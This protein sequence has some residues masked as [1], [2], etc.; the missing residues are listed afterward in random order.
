MYVRGIHCSVC[1]YRSPDNPSA[2]EAFQKAV[3][4][5]LMTFP[6]GYKVEPPFPLNL[7]GQVQLFIC[8]PCADA[9]NQAAADV[10]LDRRGGD[11]S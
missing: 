7:H 5:Q 6:R 1:G 2:R 8:R 9:F 10:V 4:L 11:R 3:T